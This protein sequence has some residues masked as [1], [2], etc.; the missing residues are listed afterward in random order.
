MPSSPRHLQGSA[1]EKAHTALLI[2]DMINDLE[3][4]EG[5][6]LFP[7]A[8]SAAQAV[9]TLKRR[10]KAVRIPVIYVNDN[11]GRWR[12][13]FSRLVRHCLADG[14][15]GRPLAEL[16]APDED[17]YFVLKP[18]L[19]GFY[20][21]TL[22]LLL[23]HLEAKRLIVTGISGNLCVLATATDAHMRGYFVAIPPDCT[24]SNTPDDNAYAL[25]LMR[26]SLGA[27]LTPSNT[28]DLAWHPRPERPSS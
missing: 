15:R 28:L 2:V 23:R 12:S 13:D 22:D 1:P 27:D 4:A 6:Q 24:A 8:L 5:P 9:A 10:T 16:L 18:A 14:V 3:F 11:F 7:A 17:D 21:T 20:S 26:Q 19:S 25:G